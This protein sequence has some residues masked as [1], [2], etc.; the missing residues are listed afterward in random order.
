M[1]FR[2]NALASGILSLAVV[3]SPALA[4]VS[5]EEAAKLG[6]ELTPIGAKKAGN[7]DEIPAWDGG[8]TTPPDNYDGKHYVDPFPEDEP[9][10]TIDQSNVDEY[11][12]RLSPGQ[13]KMIKE[14][15]DYKMPVYQTRRTAALPEKIYNKAKENATNT[16][17]VSGGNGL[18]NFDTAVPFPIPENGIQVI[19]NHITRYRGGAVNRNVHQAVPQ[20]NGDYTPIHFDEELTWR[21]ALQDYEPSK[22]SNVLFYFQQQIKSPSRLAGNVLLVHE[23]INQVK[24]PRRAWVYN[25]GQRRVRRAPQVAYDGPGT[26]SDGQRTSDNLDMFNGAPNRYNW[27]LKGKKEMYIPYNGYRLDDPSLTYDE[28]LESGHINQDHARYE[29]HRVWHVTATLKDDERHIYAKRDF[30]FDEDTW[31]AAVVDHYDG[32][33]ELWRVAEGHAMQ[34]YDQEVPWYAFETLYDTLNGRY[35]VLGLTNEM[36]DPY[37]FGIERQ[38]RDYTPSALRR[39]GRR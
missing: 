15:D 5:E 26:A 18:E 36:D 6:N 33:G 23:T 24:E 10:F 11:K 9:L 29:L 27:E 32:R 38:L 12:D 2:M 37:N 14:Y 39:S 19:W 30:Y 17:L 25:A 7:G 31:G 21:T 4:A 3:G 20:E 35:L 34:F 28:L 8:L 1:T 22:D 13:V 16:T